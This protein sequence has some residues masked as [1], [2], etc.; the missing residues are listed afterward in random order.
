M[1]ASPGTAA[2]WA[3]SL[4]LRL[5]AFLLVLAAGAATAVGVATYATVR[6]DADALFDGH[7]RQMALS[8]R[9]Q[10]RIPDEERAALERGDFDY[11]VQVWSIDGVELYS[12][13]PAPPLP[14]RAVLGFDTLEAAGRTWRV[15]SAATALR[16]VQVGQPLS[17]RRA[18]AADAAWRSVLPIAV[19]A[20]LVGLLLWWLVGWSLAPLQQVARAAASRR[21]G[22]SSALGQGLAPLPVQDLPS[23]VRPLVDAFNDLLA[24]LDAA[25]AAQ[26]DFIADAAHELRSPLTALKLQIGLLEGASDEA[27]RAE[28][29]ERLRAGIDRS[30]H[31]VG[32]LLELARAEPDS[33]LPNIQL[34]LAE[35]V[36]QALGDA[37]A[38]ARSRGVALRLVGA[39]GP[40]PARVRPDEGLAAWP[41]QGDA[42]ALRSAVRNLVDNAIRHGRPAADAGDRRPEV[43]VSLAAAGGGTQLTVDDNGPGIA[44]PER[45]RVFDR[46]HRLPGGAAEG[47]GL[48]LAIARA[49]VQRHGGR[50]ELDRS[51]SGGLRVS[52]WWPPAQARADRA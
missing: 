50:I 15:Y 8:L 10:G 29:L 11:V 33:P 16:V 17:V 24:R 19:A 18:L 1:S 22:D 12:S 43:V 20:P 5:F 6:A 30:A 42:A 13:V 3:R 21:A 14:P 36:R 41:I 28:A 2:G 34:D 37:A 40:Q 48:G 9:D 52:L 39:E 51:P 46:F 26:R 47:S 35:V 25:F 31:L 38:L 7:L 32:Q 44:P 27:E 4:R 49:V 23:E 45:E